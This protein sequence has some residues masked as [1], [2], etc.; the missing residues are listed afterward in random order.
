VYRLACFGGSVADKVTAPDFEHCIPAQRQIAK[1]GQR[2]RDNGRRRG[3]LAIYVIHQMPVAWR[4]ELYG[5]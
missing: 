4:R 3:L 1:S 2:P 5:A